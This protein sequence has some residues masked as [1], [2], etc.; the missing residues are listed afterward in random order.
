[1][2]VLQMRTTMPGV[3]CCCYF[4]YHYYFKEARSPCT[5]VAGPEPLAPS[6]LPALAYQVAE[7]PAM[8]HCT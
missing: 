8:G 1:M 6:H 2:L 3:F 7:P 5:A 4:Y